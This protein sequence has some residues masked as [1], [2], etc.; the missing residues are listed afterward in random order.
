MS[1][2][3][4][5][6]EEELLRESL[7]L[8]AREGLTT[9]VA[10]K[11]SKQEFIQFLGELPNFHTINGSGPDVF[12][13]IKHSLQAAAESGSDFIL[14]TEPD[15]KLFFDGKLTEFLAQSPLE[16]NVGVVLAARSAKS[17]ATFPKFQ[18]YTETMINDLCAEVIGEPGDY[19]YGP[20]LFNRELVSCLDLTD[21]SLGWG[22]RPFLFAMAQRKEYKTVRIENDYSCPAEQQEDNSSERI[23]RMKQLSQNIEGL[24]SATKVSL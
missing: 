9:F 7:T 16:E 22:W 14:Y 21:D 4:D 5:A 23:Y 8:L 10:D 6:Q 15:K 24:I 19:T 20:F 17:F 3:R 18:Q 11:N 1:W 2:V 13:Q 12:L